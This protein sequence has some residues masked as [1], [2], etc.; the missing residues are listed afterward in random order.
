MTGFS[1]MTVTYGFLSHC[2]Q[3]VYGT[4][5]SEVS[6]GLDVQESTFTRLVVDGSSAGAVHMSVYL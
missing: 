4:G 6:T 1:W 3:I 2:S 5:S